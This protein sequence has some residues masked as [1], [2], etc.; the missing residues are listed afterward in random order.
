MRCFQVLLQIKAEAAGTSVG[1]SLSDLDHE[2]SV[3][4]QMITLPV[5]LTHVPFSH[6]FWVV[7]LLMESFCSFET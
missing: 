1:R 3:E 4:R 5:T 2:E 7:S 6:L